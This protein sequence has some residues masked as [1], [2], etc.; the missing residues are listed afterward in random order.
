LPSRRPEVVEVALP[1]V[2]TDLGG[3]GLHTHGEPLNA[4]ADG[5]FKG[6]EEGKQEIGY[7]T[8]VAR[9]RM[10]RDEVDEHVANM[11]KATKNMIE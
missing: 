8:S 4:F 2:N 5:I 3:T 10:S 9:L 11:Y 7:G 1:A 6:L